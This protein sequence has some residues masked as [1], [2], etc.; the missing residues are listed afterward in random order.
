MNHKDLYITFVEDRKEQTE[1]GWWVCEPD[2]PPIQGP[3]KTEQ[4]VDNILWPRAFDE[5]YEAYL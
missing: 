1:D 4:E 3:F 2:G 5:A